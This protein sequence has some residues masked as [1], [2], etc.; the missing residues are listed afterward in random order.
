MVPVGAFRPT[1][2]V[3]KVALGAVRATFPA[4]VS[5]IAFSSYSASASI[6]P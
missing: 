3:S 6:Q 2:R 1:G 4:R 5:V